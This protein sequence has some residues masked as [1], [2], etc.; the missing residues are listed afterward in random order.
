MLLKTMVFVVEDSI[1]PLNA[2]FQACPKGK[3]FSVKLM[4]YVFVFGVVDVE[5]LEVEDEEAA[6]FTVNVAAAVLPS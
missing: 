5:P 1:A 6:A 4:L 2:T 3:P